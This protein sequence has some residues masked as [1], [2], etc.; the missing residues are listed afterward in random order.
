L[1]TNTGKRVSVNQGKV[2]AVEEYAAFYAKCVVNISPVLQPYFKP[3]E[4]KNPF[5]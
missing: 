1:W 5:S 2:K 4:N 3:G